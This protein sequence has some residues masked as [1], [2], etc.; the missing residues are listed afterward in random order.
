[1]DT[2][3]VM[4]GL[5]FLGKDPLALM[6]AVLLGTFILEDAAT[7]GAALLAADGFLPVPLAVLS[8]F[9]GIVL[10]DIGL[11][12]LGWLAARNSA[13][14]RIL[15]RRAAL[16][17]RRW[18]GQRLVSLVFGARFIPG[19]R[20]PSYTA[21]G[22]LGLPFWRFA[23][24]AVLATALWTSLVFALI[25]SFGIYFRDLIGLWRWVVAG[26]AVLVLMLAPRILRT[27][28]GEAAGG[29]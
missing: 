5:D 18:M 15:Q 2:D 17:L 1:M 10:G 13:F 14:G 11:Y 21:A 26:T 24:A 6:I 28:Q 25:F 3:A 20:L 29:V 4:A 7:A 19:A 8:L 16:R 22:A 27:R 9:V 12:G 23:V